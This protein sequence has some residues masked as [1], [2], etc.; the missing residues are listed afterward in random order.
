MSQVSL[1]QVFL[2]RRDLKNEIAEK[3]QSI[4]ML[5]FR[6]TDQPLPDESYTEQYALI[7]TMRDQLFA[8][9]ALIES[10]NS[11]PGSV[12]F[13]GN[14]YSLHAARHLKVHLNGAFL[15]INQQIRGIE[16]YVNRKD[17]ETIFDN[18]L[19]TPAMRPEKFGYEIL[20]DLKSMKEDEA[21]L[22]KDVKLLDSLIQKADWT[23]MV[24]VSD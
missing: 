5:A 8:Y 20:A 17:T 3:T 15:A 21:K 16:P 11:L 9:D 19:A 2:L 1:G 14:K 7:K 10:C 22:R 4:R 13:N 23:I 12:E 18:T 24:E 6:R